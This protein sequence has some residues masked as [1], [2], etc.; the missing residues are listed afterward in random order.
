MEK[1]TL[2]VVG[3]LQSGRYRKV[4]KVAEALYKRKPACFAKPIVS[5]LLEFEWEAYLTEKKHELQGIFDDTAL[6]RSVV[7]FSNEEV[8]GGADAFLQW[9]QN[10][11]DVKDSMPFPLYAAMA[12][13]AYKERFLGNDVDFVYMTISIDGSDVGKLIFELCKRL[14]PK[15]CENF[16]ALCVGHATESGQTL[17]YKDSLIHRIVAGGWIQGGDIL[18]GSG[19]H[20]ESIYGPNFPDESFSM[21]N[22]SRGIIGMA[23][24]GI[25]TNGSQFYITLKPS[26]WMDKSFVAFGKIVE[27]SDVLKKIEELP[28]RNER[29]ITSVRISDCGV[30]KAT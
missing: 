9:A 2:R 22:D 3:L 23:N 16:K 5:G 6:T 21:S 25:H 20:S 24:K 8:I 19:A 15:T 12:K 26:K 4:A 18:G 29:P 17:H 27:G 10:T 14:C 30:Y 11:H 13:D 7:V 1:E 28:A